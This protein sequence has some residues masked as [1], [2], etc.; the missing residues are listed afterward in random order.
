[1]LYNIS[2]PEDHLASFNITDIELEEPNCWDPVDNITRYV[3]FMQV[4]YESTL[5]SGARKE[6]ERPTP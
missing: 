4:I 1:M 6:K 3:I 5:L 2:C